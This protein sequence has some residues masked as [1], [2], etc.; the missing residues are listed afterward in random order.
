MTRRRKKLLIRAIVYGVVA[1]AAILVLEIALE[2]YIAFHGVTGVYLY[3]LILARRHEFGHP[4]ID[5]DVVGYF[6]TTIPPE[7]SN[8]RFFYWTPPGD[9][10]L[11][12][13][14]VLPPD[15]V[16]ALTARVA[17]MAKMEA[18]GSDDFDEKI[19]AENQV[20]EPVLRDDDNT[21]FGKLPPSFTIY[22]LGIGHG[23]KT[24]I[25]ASHWTYEY[26][27]AVDPK[28]S[29]VIYWMNGHAD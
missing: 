20:S 28:R 10:D 27:V 21:G 15:E 19:P 14:Y 16:A 6:P 3:R 17:G 9:V 13:R 8:P 22:V 11:E 23:D 24:D 5:V 25:E 7:A 2:F 29:E 4:K 18:Q 1:V 12:L 26:G